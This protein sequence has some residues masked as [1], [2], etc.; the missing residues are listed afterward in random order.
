MSDKLLLV[1]MFGAESYFII[2]IRKFILFCENLTSFRID[3]VRQKGRVMD[4]LCILMA[5]ERI[6]QA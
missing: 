3:F 2:L 4:H 6:K 1:C 5:P